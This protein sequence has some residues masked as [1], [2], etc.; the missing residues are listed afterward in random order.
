[1]PPPLPASRAGVGATHRP[2]PV[3]SRGMAASARWPTLPAS[4]CW[5]SR[6]AV[7]LWRAARSPRPAPA[8]PVPIQGETIR[9]TPHKQIL[10][11]LIRSPQIASQPRLLH[12][13]T[14]FFETA[15]SDELDSARRHDSRVVALDDASKR[16][17]TGAFTVRPAAPRAAP[18]ASGS[19]RTIF[20]QCSV[21]AKA[22]HGWRDGQRKC[23]ALAP[24]RADPP[25]VGGLARISWA[26]C[27]NPTS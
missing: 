7:A 27:V 16:R 5:R 13:E 23:R 12:F 26:P 10:T 20:L 15:T 17:E 11:P 6:A 19:S 4:E 25:A 14:A 22:R 21:C 2:Q 8:Q 3:R 24:C 9:H 1:M 18:P